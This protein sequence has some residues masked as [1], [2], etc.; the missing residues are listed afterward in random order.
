MGT[1]ELVIE[2]TGSRSRLEFM[3][4]QADDPKQRQPDISLAKKHLDWQ[5]TIPLREGLRQTI[6]Y[7]DRLLAS[8]T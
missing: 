6:S 8:N 7:F 4:L 5:P 3:P 1:A 2:I